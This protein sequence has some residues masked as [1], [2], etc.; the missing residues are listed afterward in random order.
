L[1]DNNLITQSIE[2]RRKASKVMSQSKEFFPVKKKANFFTG[3]TDAIVEEIEFEEEAD[4]N[5]ETNFYQS[6]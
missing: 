6:W 5:S 2:R 3:D 4:F 1:V